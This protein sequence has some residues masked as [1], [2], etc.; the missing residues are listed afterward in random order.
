MSDSTTTA[1]AYY[2]SKSTLSFYPSAW[3]SAYTAA[4]NWPADAVVVTD[5][6]FAAYGLASAPAGQKRGADSS[7]APAWVAA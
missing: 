6:V 3:E 2:W 4:G 7:G 5:A 1:A